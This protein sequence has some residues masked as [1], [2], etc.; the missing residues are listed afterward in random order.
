MNRFCLAL[1]ISGLLVICAH[2]ASSQN[3]PKATVRLTNARVMLDDR[4]GRLPTDV[5]WAKVLLLSDGRILFFDALTPRVWIV[6][7]RGQVSQLGRE[8]SGPGEYR[9]PGFAGEYGGKVWLFDVAQRRTSQFDLASLRH[10]QTKVWT[11]GMHDGWGLGTPASFNV[12][13]M[14]IVPGGGDKR[15]LSAGAVR[16]APLYTVDVASLRVVDSLPKLHVLNAS[17]RIVSQSPRRAIVR[18]QPFT[19]RSLFD[20]SPDGTLAVVV[21]QAEER[22]RRL[23]S[24]VVL[25]VRRTKVT[26]WSAPLALPRPSA[27]SRLQQLASSQFDM[28]NALAKTSGQASIPRSLY[29]EFLFLPKTFVPAV[30]VLIDDSGAVLIR[31]NDWAGGQVTYY[32]FLQDGRTRHE[33]TVPSTLHIRAIR[34]NR[35][36]AFQENED[37]ELTM[38]TATLAR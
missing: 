38:I 8:G 16:W 15:T 28:L 17:H 24:I 20:T 32:W 3:R 27:G 23:D 30:H 19:D 21:T 5:R 29:F 9:T 25:S 33:F 4:D 12:H 1:C 35:V 14:A 11:A 26:K 2:P 37:G 10:L 18:D 22:D 31:G 6:D 34:G 7:Q 36:V 13:G